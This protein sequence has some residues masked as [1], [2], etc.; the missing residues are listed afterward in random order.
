MVEQ[1]AEAVEAAQKETAQWK[2]RLQQ[3]TNKMAQ[4]EQKVGVRSAGRVGLLS[5]LL[6]VK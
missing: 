5:V 3:Q 4:L 6:A 2:E 1:A